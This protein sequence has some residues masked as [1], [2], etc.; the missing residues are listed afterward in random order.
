LLKIAVAVG[1][2]IEASIRGGKK[3]QQTICF[4]WKQFEEPEPRDVLIDDEIDPADFFDPG[5][6]LDSATFEGMTSFEPT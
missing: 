4:C 3:A 2:L 6:R 5:A 1:T